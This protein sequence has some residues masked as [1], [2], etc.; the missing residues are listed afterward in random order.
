M[1]IQFLLACKHV[2]AEGAGQQH[3]DGRD[4][5]GKGALDVASHLYIFKNQVQQIIT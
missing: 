3:G 1:L 5:R 2:G 4:A